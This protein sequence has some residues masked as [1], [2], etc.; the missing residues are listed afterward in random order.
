MILPTVRE[1]S[2]INLF[3]LKVTSIQS[4][5]KNILIFSSYAKSKVIKLQLFVNAVI[6]KNWIIADI[7]MLYR[8][9]RKMIRITIPAT[10]FHLKFEIFHIQAL[11]RSSSPALLSSALSIV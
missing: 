10:N 11:F 5:F 8:V 3:G 4:L 1:A 6:D 9:I 2:A 7:I